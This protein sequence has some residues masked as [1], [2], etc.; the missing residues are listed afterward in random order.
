MR[1]FGNVNLQQNQ[2]QNAVLPLAQSFP[3]TPK[4]GQIAFVNKIVYICVQDVPA[5]AVWIPLTREITVYTH[6]QS[7]SSDTWTVNHNLNTTSVNVQVYGTNNKLLIP[8]EV[9][10]LNP[11][12]ISITF[13]DS[14]QGKAVVVSGHLDGNT[15]PTYAYTFYQTDSSSTW[16]I[17]HNLGYNPIVRVFI[18]TSEV[19]PASITHPSINQ[20]IVTFSS[21][22][23][24]YAR[25]I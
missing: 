15:K 13:S 2:L 6:D 4:V 20:S 8:D 25:L 1:H 5:P 3:T 23:V 22:Q 10:I 21:P 9:E 12:Q 7:V 14:I 17:N 16:T 24:G 18:G 11:N 19:Q